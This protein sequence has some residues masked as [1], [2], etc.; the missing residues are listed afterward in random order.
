MGLPIRFAQEEVLPTPWEEEVTKQSRQ[1]A[2]TELEE[3]QVPMA[4]AA[5]F[6]KY[7]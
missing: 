1:D 6:G 3:D 7:P 5:T 2:I 4:S